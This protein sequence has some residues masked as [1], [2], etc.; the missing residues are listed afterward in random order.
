MYNIIDGGRQQGSIHVQILFLD[1]ARQSPPPP[2]PSFLLFIGP[3]R[4]DVTELGQGAAPIE[5]GP[6]PA[7]LT[8]PRSTPTPSP[9]GSI[10]VEGISRQSID[11]CKDYFR[12]DLVKTDWQLM[13]E[14]K[15]LFQIL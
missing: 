7:R 14:L 1:A 2:P 9:L 8:I 5:A 4:S 3:L 10:I 15:K 12:D 11:A 6:A 13:V